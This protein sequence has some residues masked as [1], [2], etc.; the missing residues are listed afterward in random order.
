[1][2]ECL[3]RSE[4][5]ARKTHTCDF[6]GGTIEKGEKYNHGVYK[7]DLIF[8]W[9]SHMRCDFI[10][11]EIWDLADPDEGMTEED[12]HY[13]CQDFCRAFVCPDCPQFDKEY[14]ECN[15]DA[16]FCLDRID[17][18]LQTHRLV[19]SRDKYRM[20]CFKVVPRDQS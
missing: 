15:K 12:F 9:K 6:C 11:A 16:C 14:K 13:A 20:I 3:R 7:D 2:T 8:E 17:A 5:T 19:K 4:R 1:M 10:A 18:L